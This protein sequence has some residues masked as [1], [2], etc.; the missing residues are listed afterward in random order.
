M[1]EVTK[2]RS[3]GKPGLPGKPGNGENGPGRDDGCPIAPRPDPYVRCSDA[4]MHEVSTKNR[5]TPN[6]GRYS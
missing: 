5:W 3:P 1:T 4:M 6:H 2:D